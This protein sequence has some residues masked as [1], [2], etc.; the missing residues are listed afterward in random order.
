[1]LYEVSN[2]L[3][4]SLVIEDIGVILQARGGSDSSRVITSN[5]RDSSSDLKRMLQLRWVSVTS[6][7]VPVKASI[8]VWPLS[9]R[10]VQADPGLPA[11][12][13]PRAAPPDRA[14]SPPG[15]DVS[16][17]AHSVAQMDGKMSEILSLLRGVQ[18]AGGSLAATE[19]AR[20]VR[21]DPVF[22]P[23]KMVPDAEVS[24]KVVSSESDS[25]GFDE[26]K[27]ALS[28]LRRKK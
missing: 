19:A 14:P 18:A 17:L 21:A 1:M 28:K 26:S 4:T 27:E 5:M 8:P 15:P 11:P 12:G 16:V 2:H 22:L 7:P 9:V 13:P 25:A 24:M 6:R 10:R 23:S 3:G 20:A